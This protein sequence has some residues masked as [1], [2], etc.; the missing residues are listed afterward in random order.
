MKLTLSYKKVYDTTIFT[1]DSSAE[2][3]PGVTFTQDTD[4]HFET[5]VMYPS[6]R[7]WAGFNGWQKTIVDGLGV[8]ESQA[9]V[10]LLTPASEDHSWVMDLTKSQL[11][12]I[13]DSV[14]P[15]VGVVFDP[16]IAKIWAKEGLDELGIS[17]HEALSAPN[18][19]KFGARTVAE[20]RGLRMLESVPEKMYLFR[21]IKGEKRGPEELFLFAKIGKFSPMLRNLLRYYSDIEYEALPDT[22]FRIIEEA[23][24]TIDP[25]YLNGDRTIEELLH[26]GVKPLQIVGASYTKKQANV[27][28]ASPEVKCS[29]VTSLTEQRIAIHY[30]EIF[31]KNIPAAW[32]FEINSKEVADWAAMHIGQ[33]S[34]SRVIHGPAGRVQTLHYHSLL[35]SVTPEMLDSGPKTAWRK[36]MAQFETEVAARIE[37][38]LGI[39]K[40]LPMLKHKA[41]PGAVALPNTN[42]LK[43]EG[44]VM[45]HCVGGYVNSC[46]A[47]QSYIYHVGAPAPGGATLE[48][49]RQSGKW[50]CQ[51][52]FGFKD[53]APNLESKTISESLLKEI[54]KTH[55]TRR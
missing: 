21:Y 47:K 7:S 30:T 25:Y 40:E 3:I 53:R 2:I 24:T 15:F 28:V 45:H 50:V 9:Y 1:S 5:E 41:V 27:I 37:A 51:Q 54:N 35:R 36:V 33:L 19:V 55:D 13:R 11:H 46:M 43:E 48:A 8:S 31:H 4:G 42:A 34:K 20:F 23:S 12:R 49:C 32:L 16:E 29:Y 18:A 10:M 17:I 22:F 39:N 38:D 44:E 14:S 6:Y 52:L 26:A